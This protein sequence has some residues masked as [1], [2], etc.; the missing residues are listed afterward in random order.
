MKR[1][2]CRE[3][4]KSGFLFISLVAGLDNSD[5]VGRVWVGVFTQDEA[6]QGDF[7][8]VLVVGGCEDV[9]R[10]NPPERL[11][12]PRD[13]GCEGRK[14][15]GRKDYPHYLRI[16]GVSLHKVFAG[17]AAAESVPGVGKPLS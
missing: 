11:P 16:P 15:D 9:V 4:E 12:P 10:R 8:P 2:L 3:R 14:K 5:G 17:S 1:R 6:S 7:P 13:G